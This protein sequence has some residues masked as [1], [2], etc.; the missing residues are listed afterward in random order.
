MYACTS[1]KNKLRGGRIYSNLVKTKIALNHFKQDLTTTKISIII[2]N[3][4]VPFI[5]RGNKEAVL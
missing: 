5:C 2:V 4:T 3:N 1:L